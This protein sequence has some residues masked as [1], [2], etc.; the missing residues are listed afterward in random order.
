MIASTLDLSY[1]GVSAADFAIFCAEQQRLKSEIHRLHQQAEKVRQE[2]E[3]VKSRRAQIVA[4]K[5]TGAAAL[6]AAPGLQSTLARLQQ[7][8]KE[9]I[10]QADALCWQWIANNRAYACY[11][12]DYLY[13]VSQGKPLPPRR[14]CLYR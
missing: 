12:Y 1:D 7:Q 10:D 2:A 9:L 11:G 6:A 3:T 4:R 8:E 5:Q 14:A 13:F